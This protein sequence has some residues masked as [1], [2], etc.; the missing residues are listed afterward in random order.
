MKEKERTTPKRLVLNIP[1]QLHQEIKQRAL[2]RNITLRKY[3]LQA[4]MTRIQ[5]ENKYE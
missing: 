4:L 1:E 5:N 2:D 3:V